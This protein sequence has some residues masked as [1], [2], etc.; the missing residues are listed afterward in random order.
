MASEG[1]PKSD[2]DEWQTTVSSKSKKILACAPA[3]KVSAAKQC[4]FWKDATKSGC[5]EGDNCRYAH[6]SQIGTYPAKLAKLGGSA[7]NPTKP[8]SLSTAEIVELVEQRE[9]IRLKKLWTKCDEMREVLRGH[10]IAV[11]DDGPDS[12]SGEWRVMD[13]RCGAIR[14]PSALIHGSKHGKGVKPGGKG[15]KKAGPTAEPEQP[16]PVESALA[17]AATPSDQ[18]AATAAPP[19][20]AAEAAAAAAAAAAVAAP[21]IS[22]SKDAKFVW[23]KPAA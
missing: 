20:A 7:S 3:T 9:Q 19:P 4:K 17:A 5:R 13:G 2:D 16:Q 22:Y 23:G 18:A 8:C 12:R 15:P 6:G 10:G 11:H 1:G 21:G 14:G